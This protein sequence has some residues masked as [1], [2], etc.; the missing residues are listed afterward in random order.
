MPRFTCSKCGKDI[1]YAMPDEPTHR[2]R[3]WECPRCYVIIANRR[4][5]VNQ[6]ETAT[7]ISPMGDALGD[8]VMHEVV[9]RKYRQDNPDEI[10]V[11]CEA[12][13]DW[14]N[15]GEKTQGRHVEKI[16]WADL[17]N[18]MNP[19]MGVT[20]F[21]VSNEAEYLAKNCEMYPRPW[22]QLEDPKIRLPERYIALHIRN[23]PKCESKNM[24]QREFDLVMGETKGIPVVLI[25]NDF[26]AYFCG[27]KVG[28]FEAMDFNTEILDLRT[29]LT[30]PQIG[31]VL[32][33]AEFFIGKDSGMA[34]LAAACGTRGISWG[35]ASDRYFPKAPAEAWKAYDQVLGMG[36]AL[37]R[38]RQAV[39][40]AKGSG[41]FKPGI[42]E[43][44][45]TFT[46]T[47]AGFSPNQGTV[48]SD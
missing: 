7:I 18:F 21:S 32:Q 22:F 28:L 35:Y 46:G 39:A 29:E 43:G 47:G 19:P 9:V 15:A 40:E 23:V 1:V 44:M 16:F 38:I 37:E 36:P 20:W 10:L 42:T 2:A 41:I 11:V 33:K 25:G 24:T 17:T 34:H 30:L 8:R 26:P 3:R 31:H 27:H 5:K 12:V 14:Y 6:K 4:Y 48:G 13:Q 45:D